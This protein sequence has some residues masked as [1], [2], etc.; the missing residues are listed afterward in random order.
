MNYYNSRQYYEFGQKLKKEFRS[1]LTH[2][3]C[4]Q[5]FTYSKKLSSPSYNYSHTSRFEL[6]AFRK[7]L[8]IMRYDCKT[9]KELT[10]F[11]ALSIL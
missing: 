6:N 7:T 10:K 1:C 2:K 3:T 11:A 9:I 5:L 8:R 4:F